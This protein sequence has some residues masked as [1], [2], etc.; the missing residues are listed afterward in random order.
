[1]AIKNSKYYLEKAD[2]WLEKISEYENSGYLQTLERYGT[3]A[4]AYTEM[5]KAV[6]KT[7]EESNNL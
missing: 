4:I 3:I 5:A 1:M 7:E 6:L 2:E